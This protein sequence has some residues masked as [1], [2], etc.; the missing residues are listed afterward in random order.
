MVACVFVLC[1]L[2]LLAFTCLDL[3]CECE[4]IPCS[5]AFVLTVAA[6]A[7]M[8]LCFA[9]IYRLVG[10]VD[11]STRELSHDAT[12]CLY[13]SVVTFTTLGYGDF[14]PPPELRLVAAAE[15][16]AG[17]LSLALVIAVFAHLWRRI[18]KSSN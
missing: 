6:V 3:C 10:I 13:F 12:D 16:F 8:L 7:T 4:A 18:V 9:S 15:A 1:W 11:T 17:Y 14:I 5:L 2:R